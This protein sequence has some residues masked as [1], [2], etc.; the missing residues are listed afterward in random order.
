MI[1]FQPLNSIAEKFI[2]LINTLFGSTLVTQSPLFMNSFTQQSLD[3]T[4]LQWPSTP[5]K[6]TEFKVWRV[7]I[8]F[9][10]ERIAQESERVQVFNSNLST[11]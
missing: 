6:I 7:A 11:S 3:S 4:R 8:S 9:L 2:V 10:N 1:R 5:F